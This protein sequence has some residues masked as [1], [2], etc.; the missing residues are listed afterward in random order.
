MRYTVTKH[1]GHFAQSWIISAESEEEAWDNAEHGSLIAFNVYAKPFE[2]KGYVKTYADIRATP[3]IERDQYY[4]WMEESMRNGMV[5][6]ER[7]QE[8]LDN[9]RKEKSNK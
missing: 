9:W 5:I 8:K 2:D 3:P 4:T 6:P 1:F 7:Y